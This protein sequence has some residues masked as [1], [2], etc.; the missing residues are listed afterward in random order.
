[1]KNLKLSN[2]IIILVIFFISINIFGYL[3]LLENIKTN[4]IKNQEILIYKIKN[5]SNDLS[6]EKV[7]TLLEN[8]DNTNL[9]AYLIPNNIYNI[10]L[11]LEIDKLSLKKTLP[12]NKDFIKEVLNKQILINEFY[13][14]KNS[15]K[16]YYFIKN[17]LVLNNAQVLFSLVFD[18]SSLITKV[19][20]I[21]LI[22]L[23]LISISFLLI[24]LL[25]KIRNKE[26]M[27]I[28]KDMFMKHSIHEIKTPL[29]IISLNNQLRKK[30]NGEDEYSNK[31]D[32]GIKILQSSFDDISYLLTKS[33]IHYE[34][35][36]IILGNIL[37]N[38]ITYFENIVIS[39]GRKL[40][41]SID[42]SKV[43]VSMSKVELVRLI[44]NNISNSIKYSKINTIIFIKL[45]NS[46]LKFF[47]KGKK[48]VNKEKIFKKFVREH[49]MGDGLGLGLSIVEDICKKYNIK[50]SVIFEN[51]RNI[52][53]Y[54]FNCH[55]IDIE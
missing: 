4:H 47:T 46:S 11:L 37:K 27:L 32:S 17:S 30:T 25:I 22:V 42:E 16:A 8:Y 54:T 44:D 6:N 55:I 36:I 9:K 33:N 1:M 13:E 50:K 10:N 19:N 2:Y 12:I 39:Q 48:I 29:S 23:V 15:Y 45:E 26:I 28:N 14:N 40:K 20:T 24:F 35:E 21:N 51:N 52:F 43:L 41:Y 38:R 34:K 53:E 3:Y 7:L 31:I 18:Q 49:K 5:L